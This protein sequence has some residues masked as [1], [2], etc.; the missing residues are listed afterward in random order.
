LD[1]YEH[2]RLFIREAVQPIFEKLGVANMAADTL[3]DRMARVIAVRWACYAG[4][5][6]CQKATID[7]VK[8]Y[9]AT[10]RVFE[11]DNRNTVFCAGIRGADESVFMGLWTK[12]TTSTNE[13]TRNMLIDAL[14]CSQ[15]EALLKTLLGT[16]LDTTVNYSATE[17]TRII[18]AVAN[19]GAIGAKTVTA[20]LDE[21]LA[22]TVGR[23]SS[24]VTTINNIGNWI[25]TQDYLNKFT[26]VLT[27]LQAQGAITAAQYTAAQTLARNN[28]Q[29][30]TDFGG[31][32]TAFLDDYARGDGAVQTIS[33]I[34]LLTTATLSTLNLLR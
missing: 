16:I 2:L 18:S 14:A 34:L 22:T 12:M 28:I 25:S 33:T 17:R 8:D 10:D 11:A 21:N 19:S 13:G 5:E 3:F 9:I 4:S 15:N 6:E 29:W 30:V 20:F 27:K 24:L 23:V 32:I 7:R 31:S 26:G 1:N